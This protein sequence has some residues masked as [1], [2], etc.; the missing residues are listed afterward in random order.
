MNISRKRQSLSFQ[1]DLLG[2]LIQAERKILQYPAGA[3]VGGENVGGQ[4]MP[5]EDADYIVL[6][7][8]RYPKRYYQRSE[9]IGG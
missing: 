6:G 2:Y 7:E 1:I 3:I 9:S 8:T 5:T 4:F